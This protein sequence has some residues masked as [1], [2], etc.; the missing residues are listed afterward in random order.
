MFIEQETI[1]HGRP[2][3]A[4]EDLYDDWA[5]PGFD[6]D[7]DT[8]LV[9]RQGD[10]VA[11]ASVVKH[12]PPDTYAAYGGVHPKHWGRGLGTFLFE[13]VERRVGEKAAGAASVRQWVDSKDAAAAVLLQRRGYEFERRF[14]RMDVTFEDD[15]VEPR[16]IDGVT[17]R[18]F[19]KGRDERRADDVLEEA[20]AEDWGFTPRTYEQ[21]AASRW[22]AKWFDPFM[23][24]VA[25]GGGDL[26]A[27]CINS[28]RLQDGSVDDIGVLAQWRGRGIAEAML[29]RSFALFKT[30]G[31][32]R[33]S[34]NVDSDNSTGATRLYERV[35][36]RPGTS[37][38]IYQARIEPD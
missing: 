10:V 2:E 11:Y 9:S 33:A 20:F 1:L 23:C 6:L 29:R 31:L 27:V 18:A 30:A 5:R 7:T 4:I 22:E 16:E 24:L 21:A 25:E 36:M 15:L 8:W 35:G 28:R 37:N 34:L 12:I 14:W 17:I 26:V 13:A 3:S 32:L 19:E 38:D